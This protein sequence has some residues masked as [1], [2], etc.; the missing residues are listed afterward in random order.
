ME[1]RKSFSSKFFLHLISLPFIWLPLP[2]LIILDLTIELFQFIC[3][4][5]YNIEPVKRSKYILIMD[6]N[7]LQYL[8][9]IEK[10]GCM[11]CGYAN[12]LFLYFKEIAGLTEKYW[13]GIMHEDKPGFKVQA[14]QVQENFA[15]FD[16]KKD[17]DDK[18]PLV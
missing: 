18:Y 5:I 17:F 15:R 2:I 4:P 9:I 1:Y 3:F 12:G 14:H 8:N 10:I 11:Y 7:K 16:D 6:R 13:C